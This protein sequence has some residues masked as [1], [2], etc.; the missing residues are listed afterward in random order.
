M[1]RNSE[2]SI[3][4]IYL[5]SNLFLFNGIFCLGKKTVTPIEVSFTPYKPPIRK[6]PVNGIH[7]ST[8]NTQMGWP[9][10]AE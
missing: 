1:L 9:S 8:T 10:E 2:Y 6:V 5:D 7:S 3:L 4:I